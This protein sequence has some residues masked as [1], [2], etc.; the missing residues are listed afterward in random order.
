MATSV[1]ATATM[2]GGRL[3]FAN[4]KAFGQAVGQL[5]AGV[6]HVHISPLQATRSKAQNSY[7]WRILS[8]ISEVTGMDDDAIHEYAK[9]R[10]LSKPFI[11]TD[12]SGAIIGEETVPRRSADLPPPDFYWYTEQVR[13]WAVDDLKIMT[14]TPAEFQAETGG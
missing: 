6:Y 7:Y 8:L 1:N 13:Q 5:D 14:P 10:W 4:H 3:R 12:K 11:I 2:R 9:K